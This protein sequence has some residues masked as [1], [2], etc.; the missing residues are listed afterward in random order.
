MNVNDGGL[1]GIFEAEQMAEL[2]G[3]K[4]AD[5]FCAVE[6]NNMTEKQKETNTVSLKDH[7][8]TLGKK[9][10]KE[11]KE[12]K[13]GRNDTCRCGSGIKYKKCCLKLN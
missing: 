4:F 1:H 6:A 7:R 12:R 9:L 13:L 2:K 11:R 5:M 3:K 8:S 10:T